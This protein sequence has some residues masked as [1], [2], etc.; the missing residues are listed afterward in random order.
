MATNWDSDEA[1]LKS[2]LIFLL[3]SVVVGLAVAF[4]IV[5]IRPDLLPMLGLRPEGSPHSYADNWGGGF[6]CPCHGSKFDLA[7]RVYVGVPAPTNLRIPPHRFVRDDLNLIG[8]E[9]GAS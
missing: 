8:L 3:Q 1:D 6:F 2:A 4:L 9:T 5:L 7:G